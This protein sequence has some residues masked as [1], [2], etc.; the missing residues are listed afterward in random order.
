MQHLL[1][2]RNEKKKSLRSD[3]SAENERMKEDRA[4]QEKAG[5]WERHGT[6]HAGEGHVCG[7]TLPGTGRIRDQGRM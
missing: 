5:G 6:Q 4:D 7:P 1:P 3:G 2:V